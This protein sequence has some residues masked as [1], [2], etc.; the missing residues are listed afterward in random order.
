MLNWKRDRIYRISFFLCREK[1][2][3]TCVLFL[4]Q[5]LTTHVTLKIWAQSRP[6]S[7]LSLILLN[8]KMA[9]ANALW[10]NIKGLNNT[11]KFSS[12][13]NKKMINHTQLPNNNTHKNII[14]CSQASSSPAISTTTEFSSSSSSSS[15]RKESYPCC[16]YCFFVLFTCLCSKLCSVCFNRDVK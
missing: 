14:S 3:R 9:A 5:L 2:P 1:V 10:Q 4:V 13:S 16:F 8:N 11:N 7:L 15:S 12:Y 6:L